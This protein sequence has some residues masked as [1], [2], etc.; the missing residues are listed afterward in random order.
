[1]Y[2]ADYPLE[3]LALEISILALGFLFLIVTFIGVILTTARLRRSSDA[4]LGARIAGCRGQW[5]G[6]TKA[7]MYEPYRDEPDTPGLSRRS[8]SFVEDFK[9]QIVRLTGMVTPPRTSGETTPV[10]G[11]LSGVL[12]RLSAQ[13]IS[14]RRTS[15]QEVSS[16]GG[17]DDGLRQAPISKI[18]WDDGSEEPRRRSVKVPEHAPDVDADV[19]A[20]R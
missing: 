14:P 7:P 18:Q 9:T 3:D 10:E 17:F 8:S 2:R 19:E 16:E 6:R 20:L 13:S 11:L 15:Q 12:R 1:M 4:E 5:D